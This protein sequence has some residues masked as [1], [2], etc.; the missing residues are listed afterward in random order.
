M[1]ASR[2]T[3]LLDH[4]PLKAVCD[5]LR[6]STPVAI[7]HYALV[8]AEHFSAALNTLTAPNHAE[9]GEAIVKRN[10]QPRASADVGESS[11]ET[12]KAPVFPGLFSTFAAIR[13]TA[14]MGGE[15]LE[16]PT[17]TV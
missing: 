6:N 11:H 9:Q 17:S 1:R 15:G 4:F 14:G 13:A 2:K 7:E 16:P 8:T 10:P 12:T 5:G 3:E